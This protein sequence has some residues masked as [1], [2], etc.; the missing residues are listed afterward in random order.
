MAGKTI[1]QL[2]EVSSLTA[3]DQLVVWKSDSG[4]T[5]KAALSA[6][7]SFFEENFA[8]PGYEVQTFAPTASGQ[9]LTVA[10]STSSIWVQ[11]SPAAAYAAMT[12]ALPAAA[13]LVDGQRI[14]V[15]INKGVTA[16]TLTCS[17]A[18]FAGAP[19]GL[20]SDGGSFSL[21]YSQA[22]TTLICEA[23]AAPHGIRNRTTGVTLDGGDAGV[24]LSAS[25]GLNTGS[26]VISAGS[27]GSFILTGGTSFTFPAIPITGPT[28]V[29]TSGGVSVPFTTVAGLPAASANTNFI[30]GVTDANATTPGT[31]VAGGGLNRL[32]VVSD[33]TNWKIA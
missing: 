4:A 30:R 18:T 31:N 3:G 21:R 16:L 10:S 6:L 7:L 14:L 2:S 33:G 32:L 29:A 1:Q 25:G 19:A 8:D 15:S 13:N 28:T 9:T 26:V 22:T 27:A 11:V 20:I 23:I 12:I 24:T 17:G 5:Y